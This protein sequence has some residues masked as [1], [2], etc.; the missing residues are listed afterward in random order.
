MDF[1]MGKNTTASH[2]SGAVYDPDEP[3]VCYEE[4]GI[5]LGVMNF[6]WYC[7]LSD[8]DKHTWHQCKMED[9]YSTYIVKWKEQKRKK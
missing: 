2:G 1:D 8:D 6:G 3:I 5:Q 7:E 4:F 9:K